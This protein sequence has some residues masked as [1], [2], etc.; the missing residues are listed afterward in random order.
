MLQKNPLI[1]SRFLG[2]LDP[3]NMHLF[4]QFNRAP[5]PNYHLKHYIY[6]TSDVQ[7]PLTLRHY[8]KF[9]QNDRSASLLQHY[10]KFSEKDTDAD[11]R[12]RLSAKG[13]YKKY[14][15]TWDQLA[16]RDLIATKSYQGVYA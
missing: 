3:E 11:L 16:E 6:F 5:A 15:R 10:C 7:G 9:Y 12:R 4:M 13:P 8:N 2:N 1:K 14:L